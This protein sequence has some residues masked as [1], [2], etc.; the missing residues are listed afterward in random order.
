MDRLRQLT[1][2]RRLKLVE[3]NTAGLAGGDQGTV[4]I[5]VLAGGRIGSR[6]KPLVEVIVPAVA[7]GVGS[8]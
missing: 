1:G 8:M 5:A 3:G 6:R 7:W 2:A 4:N